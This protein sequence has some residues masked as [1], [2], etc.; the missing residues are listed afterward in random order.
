MVT[1]S[2]LSGI[3]TMNDTVVAPTGSTTR[4]YCA[5]WK[6]ATVFGAYTACSSNSGGVGVTTTGNTLG[7]I[8]ANVTSHSR[9]GQV[10]TITLA[11]SL[12]CAVGAVLFDTNST[13]STFSGF[14]KITLCNGATSPI[15]TTQITYS[16]GY[17][18]ALPIPLQPSGNSTNASTGGTVTVYS[19]DLLTLPSV[20]NT[21]QALIYA[22]GSSFL[23]YT[24]PGELN[25][26]NFGAAAPTLNAWYP[27]SAPAS[28]GNGALV[29]TITSGGGTSSV[30]VANPA[31]QSASGLTAYFDDAPTM[32]AACT[33]GLPV[34]Q[35]RISSPP[36]SNYYRLNSPVS[37][38]GGTMVPAGEIIVNEPLTLTSVSLDASQG[39]QPCG[40]PAFGF[41]EGACIQVGGAY[42]GVIFKGTSSVKNLALS[43][44]ANGFA[45][46]FSG[47]GFNSSFE[48]SSCQLPSN[49]IVGTCLVLYGEAEFQMRNDVFETNDASGYGYFFGPLGY[50]GMTLPKRTE[51][52]LFSWSILS[53]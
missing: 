39:S 16:Q 15:F 23:G 43:A 41:N 45:A 20:A 47:S 2:L 12:P 21:Y 44:G 38:S 18:S 53:S 25:W 4:N 1:P 37:C 24:R 36:A 17:T 13:D 46:E 42:P 11:T 8:T 14:Y 9:S 33:A 28:A 30:V 40:F 7:A 34:S 49:D 5:S 51:Q 48:R 10:V 19:V 32:Q 52:A 22:T 26:T 35:L 50:R 6:D 27:L 31:T 3:D 29:T